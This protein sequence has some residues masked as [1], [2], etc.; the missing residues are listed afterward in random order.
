LPE[1]LRQ[2]LSTTFV[3]AAESLV[4]F[5]TASYLLNV[6]M[7]HNSTEETYAGNHEPLTLGLFRSLNLL[8]GEVFDCVKNSGLSASSTTGK[9]D[10][11]PDV[12]YR[13]PNGF[14]CFVGEEK[15]PNVTLRDAKE[16]LMLAIGPWCILTRGQTR[17]LFFFCSH[18][19]VFQFFCTDQSNRSYELS[20]VFDF[21]RRED[22]FQMLVFLV[23][24]YRLV[25]GN[26]A[27][28]GNLDFPSLFSREERGHSFS[29]L[30]YLASGV[31][32]SFSKIHP[33]FNHLVNIH[34]ALDGVDTR[35]L[36]RFKAPT[37]T[38]SHLTVEY[39]PLCWRVTTIEATFAKRGEWLR[40]VLRGLHVL[41]QR[42][43][44]HNDIRVQNVL[45]DPAANV[46]VVID[47]D[48]CL[49]FGQPI[50]DHHPLRDGA[51]SAASDL[52]MVG[53]IVQSWNDDAFTEAAQQL[54]NAQQAEECAARLR[55]G[56]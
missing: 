27:N 13:N 35:H 3:D 15:K 28:C 55:D 9:T 24:I 53:Q 4:S 31:T 39:A 48:H 49:P 7:P 43:W 32:R 51:C 12:V 23:K 26:L 19:H 6:P 33:R 37:E 36:L 44:A 41:H 52:C 45:F 18:G 50:P 29:T 5:I 17:V 14:L 10:L 21:A 42:G 54:M 20:P 34:N 16:Q 8:T 1:D 40:H 46:W 30:T 47:L 56:N 38:R 2:L 11:R 25:R 22:R